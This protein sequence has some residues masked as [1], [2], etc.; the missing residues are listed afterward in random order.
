MRINVLKR[1]DGIFEINQHHYI[2]KIMDTLELNDSKGSKY[3]LDPGYFKLDDNQ[4][5]ETN[6][7]Y[8]KI[9]GM[10]LYVSTNTRPDISASVN[11]LAQKVS[12]PRRLDLNESLRIVKYLIHTKHLYSV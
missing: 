10:L 3:P 7:Q 9:I 12:K 6:T 11:I 4:F 2:S 5:L 1:D 8:R